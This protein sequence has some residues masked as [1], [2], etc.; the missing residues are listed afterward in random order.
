MT[1]GIQMSLAKFRI[2]QAREC[3]YVAGANMETSL[4]SSVRCEENHPVPVQGN[5]FQS[6]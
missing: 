6:V 1:N 3:L 4:K 5:D 2:E